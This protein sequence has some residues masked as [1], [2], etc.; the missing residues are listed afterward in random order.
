MRYLEEPAKTLTDPRELLLGYA[1]AYR[2]GIR[3]KVAERPESELYARRL[4]SGWTPLELLKHL[5]YMERRWFEWGFA[6]VAV[7][8]PV[9][10][11]DPATGRWQVGP[12]ETLANILAMLEAVGQSAGHP[13]LDLLARPAG[14][15]PSSGPP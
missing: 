13:R 11:E 1:E 12:D 7:P 4:P 3:C 8:D 9:G 6:G 14:L 5:A 15:R 2:N 10:D